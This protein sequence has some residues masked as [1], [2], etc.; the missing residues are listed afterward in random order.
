MGSSA[1]SFF[2][3]LLEDQ[4]DRQSGVAV[5]L[6]ICKMVAEGKESCGLPQRKL[7]CMLLLATLETKQYVLDF[8]ASSIHSGAAKEKTAQKWAS[9]E[10]KSIDLLGEIRFPIP[11]AKLIQLWSESGVSLEQEGPGLLDLAGTQL[12]NY[13]QMVNMVWASPASLEE[14]W[15]ISMYTQLARMQAV[16]RVVNIAGDWIPLSISKIC[17]ARDKFDVSLLTSTPSPLQLTPYD[18]LSVAFEDRTR[19][20]LQEHV[21][22]TALS[23]MQLQSGYDRKL[24]EADSQIECLKLENKQ[25]KDLIEQIVRRNSKTLEERQ[26]QIKTLEQA[27]TEA[28]SKAMPISARGAWEN[29]T[30]DLE[31]G[32]GLPLVSSSGPSSSSSSSFSSSFGSSFEHERVRRAA[33]V[34]LFGDA[35]PA[36]QDACLDSPPL[37]SLDRHLLSKE[38]D[39][40][41]RIKNLARLVE[42]ALLELEQ[43]EHAEMG[44]GLEDGLNKLLLT[45]D[46]PE[47]REASTADVFHITHLESQIK[48]LI[49]AYKKRAANLKQ[50]ARI[51]AI[52]TAE[53]DPIPVPVPIP[54]VAATAT[55]TSNRR[56]KNKRVPQNSNPN[57]AASAAATAT[58]PSLGSSESADATQS[59]SLP[60]A[61]ASSAQYEA[62]LRNCSLVK[63]IEEECRRTYTKKIENQ[64]DELN[65]SEQRIKEMTGTIAKLKTQAAESESSLVTLKQ[66][67]KEILSL[68][69]RHPEFGSYRPEKMPQPASSDWIIDLLSSTDADVDL[70]QVRADLEYATEFGSRAQIQQENN[71]LKH[72]IQEHQDHIDRI[73]ETATTKQSENDALRAELAAKSD[74]LAQVSREHATAVQ[75]LETASHELVSRC[76]E[77]S[78]LSEALASRSAELDAANRAIEEEQTGSAELAQENAQLQSKSDE[79][80]AEI[81][82]HQKTI[83]SLEAELVRCKGETLALQRLVDESQE[84]ISQLQ[85]EIVHLQAQQRPTGAGSTGLP[86]EACSVEAADLLEDRTNRILSQVFSEMAEILKSRLA[87]KPTHAIAPPIRSP[88]PI[89]NIRPSHAAVQRAEVA[90][91]RRGGNDMLLTE[92]FVSP[93]PGYPIASPPT[94]VPGFVPHY[95]VGLPYLPPSPSIVKLPFDHGNDF[96]SSEMI[97]QFNHAVR[98]HP[99]HS[100]AMMRMD[101]MAGW[102]EPQ[103]YPQLPPHSPMPPRTHTLPHGQLLDRQLPVAAPAADTEVAVAQARSTHGNANDSMPD[104]IDSHMAG[105]ASDE[106]ESEGDSIIIDCGSANVVDDVVSA[107]ASSR[108]YGV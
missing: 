97:N 89:H 56:R 52:K 76:K 44:L 100:P 92:P 62:S 59:T 12:A 16:K 82:V 11:A 70:A 103:G 88:A 72:K 39:K 24:G 38:M 51:H 37:S 55:T 79:L 7:P 34:S 36:R 108:R 67:Y 25:Q 68:I 84:Y 69:L 54:V 15:V 60:T 104:T 73:R 10:S 40:S 30:V 57:S 78:A 13:L 85:H 106:T 81:A 8:T 26:Q 98:S 99:W 2:T 90:P 71:A 27:L 64:R 35:S 80:T 91:A 29:D 77:Q 49:E 17:S 42:Q 43:E 74:R 63:K 14:S 86:E 75:E 21:S 45:H 4:P 96:E 18:Q 53:E 1:E 58:V 5:V 65:R 87:D 50:R 31:S 23:I 28:R 95:P 46:P 94:G 33:A 20:E 101:A 47:K 66:R 107:A 61:A 32:L 22:Q 93:A 41:T 3:R 19:R 105:A 102:W 83:D 48:H 9:L 6:G